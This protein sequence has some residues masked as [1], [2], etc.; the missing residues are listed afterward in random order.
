MI[1]F[2]ESWRVRK[3]NMAMAGK[4]IGKYFLITSS[5]GGVSIAM[6]VFREVKNVKSPSASPRNPSQTGRRRLSNRHVWMHALHLAIT[7]QQTRRGLEVTVSCIGCGIFFVTLKFQEMLP[8]I[9]DFDGIWFW[10]LR[11]T[12]LHMQNNG[13]RF[14]RFGYM[15]KNSMMGR[16]I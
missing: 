12:H 14:A 5:N 8:K 13:S 11:H 16:I 7:N 2:S 1:S 15:M 4:S 9:K 6:F 10:D 3:T